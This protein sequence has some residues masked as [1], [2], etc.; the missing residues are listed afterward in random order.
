M[1]GMLVVG[2]GQFWT[3]NQSAR[4][5]LKFGTGM[6]WTTPNTMAIVRNGRNASSRKW[7]VLDQKSKFSDC[8]ETGYRF[9]L[10]HAQHDGGR[11]EW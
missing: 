10:D 11:Q 9:G 3:K 1:L 2:K 8:A 7:T 5:V 6:V 4:I